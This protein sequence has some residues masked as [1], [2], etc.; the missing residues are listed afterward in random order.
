MVKKPEPILKAGVR[1]VVATGLTSVQADELIAAIKAPPSTATNVTKVPQS[2]GL[3]TV[4]AT[5]P[6]VPKGSG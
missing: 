6:A 5:F 2:G 3:F 4:E 1:V